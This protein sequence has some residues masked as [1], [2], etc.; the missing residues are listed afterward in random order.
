[1]TTMAQD[2]IVFNPVANI[3]D[4][5]SLELDGSRSITT[6]VIDGSTY[7]LVAAFDDDGVQIIDITD[8]SNPTPTASITDSRS[9]ALDGA[10]SIT[11]EEI[12][13]RTYALV[14]A[15]VDNGVQIIDITDPTNP[16]PT[17]SIIDTSSLVLAGAWSITTVASG[18]STYALV[19]SSYDNGVQIIDI[20][21]PTTPIA[22]ASITDSISRE[23][24]GASGITTVVI[25]TST[26]ALVTGNDDDGIQIIDI[27]DPTTPTAT[28][29]LTDSSSLTLDNAIGITTVVIGEQTYALVTAQ[30]DDGVQIIDITDPSNPAPTASITDT[31]RLALDYP[32]A[33]VTVVMGT[34][35]YALVTA[36]AD[37]GF[38]IIDISSPASPTGTAY[39]TDTASLALN[40]ARDI[41]TV[42]ING[43]NYVLVAANGDDG[44]QIMEFGSDIQPPVFTLEGGSSISLEAGY[45]FDP[46]LG[47]SAHDIVDGDISQN[48]VVS[49]DSVDTTNVGGT[50]TIIYTVSD[51]AGN[52]ATATI[53][54]TI[55][56]DV[57]PPVITP[58]GEMGYFSAFGELLEGGFSTDRPEAHTGTK[59]EGADL[60]GFSQPSGV[61]CSGQKTY[62]EALALVAAVGARLPTLQELQS[63]VTQGT[64]CSYE[65]EYIWTQ[66]LGNSNGERMVDTGSF[67]NT[68]P[69]SLS[70]TSTAYVRYVYD[71]E[72]IVPVVVESKVDLGDPYI[73]AGATAIDFLDGNLTNRIVTVNPVD[74]S[75]EGVYTVTYNVSDAA[76]NVAQEVT[77]TVVVN[78]VL[79]VIDSD[80]SLGAGM[81]LYPNPTSELL[82]LDHDT[83]KELYYVVYDLTGKR[84]QSTTC[85]GTQHVIN[86]S[87]L[88]PGVY[89]LETHTSQQKNQWRFV[90]E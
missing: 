89:I 12:G 3:T 64:G 53:T 15:Y 76:G 13:G 22:T 46:L 81:L 58:L 26:Y 44:V 34:T 8:P 61:E 2:A 68:N 36:V 39:I 59:N 42:V 38:Q 6:V 17:A 79:S 16:S 77:R 85:S 20:T 51:A 72:P 54:V 50:Y 27:T 88:A 19:T 24:N 52:E 57:T 66:T 31:N 67:A 18:T 49:G 11:T 48:I 75:V 10:S 4:T 21:D 90:K 7:A 70:E 35:T 9:L 43:K 80:A 47:I 25:G 63:N 60:T 86:V 5:S 41:T 87:P 28:A 37:N 69:Q 32:T 29:S 65:V 84:V 62:A 78:G 40:G 82:H 74:T 83:A 14:A 1:L 23:L 30:W 55:T 71:N 33:V 73:D 45:T 56:A